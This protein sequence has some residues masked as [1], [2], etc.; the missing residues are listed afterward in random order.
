VSL[1][2]GCRE[3]GEGDADADADEFPDADDD[4]DTATCG[5]TL[6]N[7]QCV[8]LLFDGQNCGSCGNACTSG[9]H[10]ENSICVS[11]CPPGLESCSGY[12]LNTLRDSSNCGSCG[13]VCASGQ[14]CES[15]YCVGG[16]EVC[17]SYDDDGDGQVDEELNQPC[18]NACGAGV[19]T[20][21]DGSWVNC[22][23]PS[24]EDEVCDGDDNDCDGQTDE[25]V[26]ATLW[27]DEDGDSFGNSAESVLGC[28]GLAGTA[29]NPD[30]CDDANAAVNP[31][32]YEICGDTVDNDC[33]GT[34]DEGC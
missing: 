34:S 22:T 16:L 18:N 11:E 30:D 9:E 17:N 29:D 6:C 33:D 26:A 15:G 31:D 32:A 8:N 5:D 2:G 20:C 10:C 28:P 25:G 23:A 3:G 12:C 1:G 27:T 7:G 21:M 19:E 13:N 14:G 4:S 24:P